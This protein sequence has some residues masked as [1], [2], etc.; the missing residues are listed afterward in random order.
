M[1][2]NEKRKE[3]LKAEKNDYYYIE[4]DWS[5]VDKSGQK[6]IREQLTYNITKLIRTRLTHMLICYC[7]TIKKKKEKL[8]EKEKTEN[9]IDCTIFC[10]NH[11]FTGGWSLII[12]IT[13][14][15]IIKMIQILPISSSK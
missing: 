7:Y 5:Y 13:T 11:Q 8:N 9:E 14:I 12:I 15:I 2:S 4:Y 3:Q 1:Q 6:L 10:N